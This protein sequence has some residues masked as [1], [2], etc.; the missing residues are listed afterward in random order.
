MPAC[1][2][3][4]CTGFEREQG[5][6]WTA[7][8]HTFGVSAKQALQH[9][10]DR[11]Q[12][13]V[14]SPE[15]VRVQPSFVFYGLVRE[16]GCCCGV[17]AGMPPCEIP[18]MTRPMEVAQY[19]WEEI[20]KHDQEHDAVSVGFLKRPHLFVLLDGAPAAF[21]GNKTEKTAVFIC[22]SWAPAGATLASREQRDKLDKFAH[23]VFRRGQLVQI[24]R[25]SARDVC[26][27]ALC[28][29]LG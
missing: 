19:S 5:C 3:Q 7:S 18:Q 27:C 26:P 9:G 16:L 12:K 6:S 13:S 11:A 14:N 29:Y 8:L 25:D 17:A 10:R 2:L 23:A 24:Q 4:T 22:C 28:L 20:K 15:E 1:N 21:L